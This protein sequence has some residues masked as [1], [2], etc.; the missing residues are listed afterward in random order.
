MHHCRYHSGESII[1]NILA[2]P[3]KSIE[4][5]CAWKRLTDVGNLLH[6]MKV[7]ALKRGKM[8]VNGRQLVPV[9]ICDQWL[10]C[11]YC[12]MFYAQPVIVR[13][14]RRCPDVKAISFKPDIDCYLADASLFLEDC[15]NM[16]HAGTLQ[17][18]DFKGM[19]PYWNNIFYHMFIVTNYYCC[20]RVNNFYHI[21]GLFL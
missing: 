15:I 10:P 6:N 16:F 9:G 2:M 12:Y 14:F 19:Y 5:R 1:A 3:K 20:C 11:P 7:M 4:R 13:H 17:S 8:I 21:S 18:H